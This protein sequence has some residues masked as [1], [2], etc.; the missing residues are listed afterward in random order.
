MSALLSLGWK[1]SYQNLIREELDDL[2][3][4]W[5]LRRFDELMKVGLHTFRHDIPEMYVG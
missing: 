1:V 4:Q 3:F 2:R 5:L